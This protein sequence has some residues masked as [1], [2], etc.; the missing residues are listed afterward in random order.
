MSRESGNWGVRNYAGTV[1]AAQ[2]FV[3]P[4]QAM[5]SMFTAPCQKEMGLNF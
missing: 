3:V 5:F 2:A 4:L 1:L